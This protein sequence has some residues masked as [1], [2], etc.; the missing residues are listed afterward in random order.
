VKTCSLLLSAILCLAI[1]TLFADTQLTKW[2]DFPTGLNH[3]LALEGESLSVRV[4]VV[5]SNQKDIA[6]IKAC[7]VDVEGPAGRPAGLSDKF[8]VRLESSTIDAGKAIAPSLVI[9]AKASDVRPGSYTLSLEISGP[10]LPAESPQN[11]TLTL[12]RDAPQ[13]A[14]PPTV[15][16]GQEWCFSNAK[17]VAGAFAI[18]EDG[19]KVGL[20]TFAIA[21]EPDPPTLPWRKRGSLDLKPASGSV[22]ASGRRR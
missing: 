22:S 20:S 1:V 8:N 10:P 6:T 12:R 13:V 18:R 2:L 17:P 14:T 21:D 5:P 9:T 16:I 3:A 4:R 11:A 7:L 19:H 15:I